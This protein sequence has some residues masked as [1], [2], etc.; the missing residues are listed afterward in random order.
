[1]VQVVWAV[2]AVKVERL[3]KTPVLVLKRMC[4]LSLIKLYPFIW[5]LKSQ[6]RGSTFPLR[7]A[8]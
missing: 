4:F 6:G 3:K 2:R 1:M 5:I 7:H 8:L